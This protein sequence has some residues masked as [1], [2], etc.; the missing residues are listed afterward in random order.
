MY[1]KYVQTTH[2]KPAYFMSQPYTNVYGTIQTN[3]TRQQNMNSLL[4]GVIY[5]KTLCIK[6]V[7]NA[8]PR[9]SF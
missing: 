6:Y 3:K 2:L 7:W 5:Y 1:K 4:N 8:N 9:M